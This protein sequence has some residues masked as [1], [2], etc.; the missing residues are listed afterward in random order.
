MIVSLFLIAFGVF[1]GQEY[2]GLPVVKTVFL[3]VLE[4]ANKFQQENK[5]PESNAESGLYVSFFKKFYNAMFWKSNDKQK[6]QSNNF[7]DSF[8]QL[9]GIGSISSLKKRSL[10]VLSEDE[11]TVRQRQRQQLPEQL[12]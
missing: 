7:N 3:N 6:F 10:D 11:Y 12:D 9:N 5:K 4:Y 2:T 1:L 8:E